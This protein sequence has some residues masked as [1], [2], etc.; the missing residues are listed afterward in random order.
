ML[1]Q[2]AFPVVPVDTTAAGDTFCG[3]LVAARDRGLAWRD[4]LRQ[5]SAAAAIA[6]TRPGAQASIPTR[7]EVE[8]FLQANAVHAS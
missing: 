3:A 8:A 4:T 5:A 1:S 6:C 7:A 2:A